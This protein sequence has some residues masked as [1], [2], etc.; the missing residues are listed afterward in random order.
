MQLDQ[1]I[2]VVSMVMEDFVYHNR[3]LRTDWNGEMVF[4][5]EDSHGRERYMK[6]SY[7]GGLLHVEA[8]LK[9]PVGGEMDLNG[10][11]G[12]A[13]RKEFRECM[14]KLIDT[15]KR[16]SGA[17]LAGGHIGSDPLHHDHGHG[18]NHEA[19]KNDTQWQQ[20]QDKSKAAPKPAG[21]NT[22]APGSGISN[23]AAQRYATSSGSREKG[24]QAPLN[25]GFAYALIA[26]MFGWGIP[27]LGLV[28]GIYAF[29]KNDSDN[30]VINIM[31]GIAIAEAIVGFLISIVTMFIKM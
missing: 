13:S 17:S 18:N 22:T 27:I 10:V 25:S 12:G 9:N 23:T 14:D 5:M 31:A 4:F 15:L 26:L 8:W 28:L 16:Q 21:S 30:R 2:D 7:A 6:W 19:W 29:R 20:M 11:G 24:T 3:F 1:P